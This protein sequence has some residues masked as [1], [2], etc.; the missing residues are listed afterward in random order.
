MVFVYNNSC[1]SRPRNEEPTV[2]RSF[3]FTERDV[4]RLRVLAER[5]ELPE[6]V[7]VR[8]ALKEKAERAEERETP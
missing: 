1:M 5:L 2:V 3:R 7:V 6:V 8:Q 4:E